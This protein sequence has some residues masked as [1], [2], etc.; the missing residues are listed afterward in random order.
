MGGRAA[1]SKPAPADCEHCRFCGYTR[2]AQ[3][4]GHMGFSAVMM[5]HPT[6]LHMVEQKIKAANRAKQEGAK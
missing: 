1:T 2:W 3:H 4:I 6:A 5:D